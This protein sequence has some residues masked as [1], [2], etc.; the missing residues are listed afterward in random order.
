MQRDS[1]K[2]V[3]AVIFTIYFL[4]CAYSPIDAVFLHF[5]HTP[6][7]EAGHVFF[8]FF[9]EFMGIAGG[10]LFQVVVPLVFFGY[11]VWQ[12]KPFSAAI[13]L[14]WVGQ[15]ITDVSV[16]AADAVVM[17]L[18]LLSGV[19]GSEG[20]FHDWNYLLTE[21][22]LLRHTNLIANL[23]RFFGTVTIILASVGAFL[24]ARKGESVIS[25]FDDF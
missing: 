9:G 17:Q 6:I 16:Y 5:V 7:H 20:G 1:F 23:L 10:S 15:S 11:F 22:G 14:F 8:R 4:W 3:L 24:Y 25:D 21:T 18:P 19:T 2:I 13:V 12:E